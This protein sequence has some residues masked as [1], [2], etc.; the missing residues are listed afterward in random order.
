[1]TRSADAPTP[2]LVLDFDGTVCLGDAPVWAYADAVIDELARTSPAAER[3]AEIR[4]KLAAFL[5]GA[6]ESPAYADGYDAVARLIGTRATPDQLQRAYSASRR[7]LASGAVDVSAPPGLHDFLKAISSTVERVLVTN[8]PL[9]GV[10]ET[11]EALGL[12]DVIG[13]VITDAGKPTGWAR[14]LPDLVEG[15]SPASVM[16]VGDIWRN[17]IAAPLDFGCA[18]ALVDHYGYDQGPSHLTARTLEELYPGLLAWAADPVGFVAAHPVSPVSL[19]NRTTP[20]LHRT[21]TP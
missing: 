1:V 6:P 21:G 19:R 7:A 12:S 17:D 9:E 5:D 3:D 8:A 18:T 14:L 4:A 16:V 10:P 11:I 20:P 13:R 15:R 2:V